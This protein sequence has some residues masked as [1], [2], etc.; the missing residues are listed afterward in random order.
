M[1]L[2]GD[3]SVCDPVLRV[4]TSKNVK[5]FVASRPVN[6]HFHTECP[7]HCVYST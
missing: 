7:L 6:E 3:H 4:L 2:F 1:L 5:Y